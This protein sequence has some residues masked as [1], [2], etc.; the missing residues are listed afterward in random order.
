MEWGSLSA[1]KNAVVE[2]LY[3]SVQII[4]QLFGV[5]SCSICRTISGRIKTLPEKIFWTAIYTIPSSL[6]CR[7]LVRWGGAGAVGAAA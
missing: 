2:I 3:Y 6:F 7:Y 1:S 4:F 5:S